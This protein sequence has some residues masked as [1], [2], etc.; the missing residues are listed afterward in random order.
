MKTGYFASLDFEKQLENELVGITGKH[1]RLF[2]AEGPAQNVHWAQNI[3]LDVQE[4][5]IRSISDGAKK[6]R[7]LQKLWA[8]YPE[9][10]ARRGA[11]ITEELPYFSPKPLLFPSQLP[12][13]PLGSWMLL[14]DQTIL[15]SAICTSPFAHGEVHFQEN[16]EPPSRAYLK[17]FEALTLLGEFP[18]RGDLCLDLG[19][20]PGSWSWTLDRLG[21]NVLAIDRSPLAPELSHIPFLK[22]DAFS[23]QISPD[24][25]WIFC[26][27]AC[28][29][30]KLLEWI[31][32][33]LAKGI[34]AHFVCTLKFQGDG[35]EK[36]SHEFQKIEGSRIVKLYHNKHELTWL[37]F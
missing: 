2:I 3:W 18:Q 33:Q 32:L 14:N 24:V 37:R 31:H 11:L 35:S 19:A 20:S 22:E 29:P 6:L 23:H 17:L 9:N 8:F 34:K 26:D 15:A 1:G 5:P 30:E 25:K 13:A 10:L 28:Y 21:A 7:A 12:K 27:V 4:I 16:K 36:I